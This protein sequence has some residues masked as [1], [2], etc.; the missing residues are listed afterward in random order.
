MKVNEDTTYRKCARCLND[1]PSWFYKGSKGWHCRRCISFGRALL[2]EEQ[3]GI[4]LK[5][6]AEEA[7]EYTLRYP[8]SEEQKIIAAGVLKNIE[9]ADV[10]I[11]AV[12]GAGKTEIV[13]PTIANYLSKGKKV[14]FAI[15]RRQVVLEVAKRLA[16]YFHHAKVIGVCGGHTNEI[17]GDLIVCTTHQL[18]RYCQ[19]AFDLLI[20]D[21]PDAFPFRND[22]VLHGIARTSCKGNIIYLTA[23]PDQTLKKRI[24]E[25]DLVCLKLNHRPHGKPLP[26]PAI[27][28]ADPIINFIFLLRWLKKCEKHPRI[29]FVPTISMAHQMYKCLKHFVDCS[30]CTSKTEQRDEVISNFR[31]ANNGIMIATTVLERGV[32]IPHCDVCVWCAENDVFDEAGLIQMAGRAGRDFLDPY[33]DVLFLCNEKSDKV[34]WCVNSLKEANAS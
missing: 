8:L 33:G 30:I 24:E 29:V 19:G 3:E 5:E 28:I 9:I 25:K 17:D 7:S 26:V 21:E 23:T 13:V 32:T 6:I 31:N 14:C 15:A 22:P 16:G 18:Y 12:C 34:D 20:L 10:L 1:D 2:E 11:C 27:R 4:H